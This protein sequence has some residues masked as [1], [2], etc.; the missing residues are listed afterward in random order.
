MQKK[1]IGYLVIII[2]LIIV[3]IGVALTDYDEDDGS[4]ASDAASAFVEEY[5]DGAF[6]TFTVDDDASDEAAS[7]TSSTE[8]NM[9][10][11]AYTFSV[12]FAV[13]EDAESTYASLSSSLS[14][15]TSTAGTIKKV[16]ISGYDNITAYKLDSTHYGAWTLLYFIA[17]NDDQI[18]SAYDSE[19]ESGAVW[20]G[21]LKYS[22]DNPAVATDDEIATILQA[23]LTAIGVEDE[24]T[25]EASPLTA[26]DA[27]QAMAEVTDTGG[28]GTYTLSD[29]A[30]ETE[31]TVSYSGAR[32]SYEIT[33]IVADDASNQY[34]K[35]ASDLD[36]GIYSF[37]GSTL[38]H[39]TID[40]YSNITAWTNDISM[41]SYNT[42]FTYIYLVAYNGN[43]LVK[44][45]G[46]NSDGS[47]ISASV[48]LY[49]A[50]SIATQSENATLINAILSTIGVTDTVTVSGSSDEPS[51]DDNT[52]STSNALVTRIAN[53]F[54]YD[55]TT[56]YG[57]QYY[58]TTD[59]DS[60]TAGYPSSPTDCYVT[61][62]QC[63]S[64]SEAK[65]LYDTQAAQYANRAAA[66]SAMGGLKYT[67]YTEKGQL[68]GGSGYYGEASAYGF[69]TIHYC[70]YQGSIYV[71][72]SLYNFS[73]GTVADAPVS[74]VVEAIYGA[75]TN[76][77][78]ITVET[79]VNNFVLEDD[80]TSFK[81]ENTYEITL[82]DANNASAGYT[83]TFTGDMQVPNSITF[84]VCDSEDAAKA[85]YDTQAAN[86][87]TRLSTASTMGGLVYLEI[88]DS[89]GLT[90]GHGYYGYIASQPLCSIHYGGYVGNVYFIA[91][92][93][94]GSEFADI[95]ISDFIG[96]V[97]TA[98]AC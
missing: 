72:S 57:S 62:M 40:G 29:G 16:E 37:M 91:S 11:H 42:Y 50:G 58:I 38:T 36:S 5:G 47:T 90:G 87:A 41:A 28:Y 22:E 17:Y 8:L 27:A 55:Y 67:A 85:L 4:S 89:Y 95:D 97:K 63:S 14:E 64:E 52:S 61:F 93:W 70:A 49:H 15:L 88:P 92:Y 33:Y 69:T 82:T 32:G 79:I 20:S 71:D 53:A 76:P 59:G 7:A 78:D 45:M 84:T 34:S 31:A 26:T 80:T 39:L 98:I 18:V 35:L 60:A 12:K 77:K 74:A 19:Y 86:D 1:Y 3:I 46:Y 81:G 21:I 6:G 66:G 94:I 2:L 75:I 9:G 48:G 56:A 65:E 96:A 44:A 73:S 25:V 83:A 51:D 43:T 23:A 24:I 68:A 54:A 13:D 10:P 30:T